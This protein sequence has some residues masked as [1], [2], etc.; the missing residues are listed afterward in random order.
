MSSEIK[1]VDAVSAPVSGSACSVNSQSVPIKIDASQMQK[2]LQGLVNKQLQLGAQGPAAA[3]GVQTEQVERINP[4]VYIKGISEEMEKL[5]ARFDR[6]KRLATELHGRQLD[7]PLP[8][9]VAL[10]NIVINFAVTKDGKT[11]EH[12]AEIHTVSSI[13]DLTGLMSTEFGFIILS[14]TE[15]SKQLADL[16]QKTGDRCSSALKEWENNNKDKKIV[17]SSNEGDVSVDAATQANADAPITLEA[18]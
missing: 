5:Y 1:V 14:L 3:A 10:K 2:A 17:R 16:A 6:L 4:S 7:A 15:Q 18:S 13:G 9:H 8:E 12:S 11:E